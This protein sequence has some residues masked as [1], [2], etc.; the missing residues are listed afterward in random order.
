MRRGLDLLGQADLLLAGEQG[1]GAHLRQVHPDGVV[2]AAAGGVGPE[3]LVALDRLGAEGG[4]DVLRGH[5]RPAELEAEP[6]RLAGALAAGDAH[7]ARGLGHLAVG[8][9]C[10]AASARGAVLSGAE[11]HLV[12]QLDAGQVEHHEHAV[13]VTR[14]D[15]LVGERV[16]QL[17]VAEPLTLPCEL[18]ELGHRWVQIVDHGFLLASVG[19]RVRFIGS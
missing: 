13:D 1:D 11:L 2:D 14:V 5:Q 12:D 19:H 10:A 4:L 9:L 6:V 8:F 16:V 7:G 3:L 15:H 17:L 18:D